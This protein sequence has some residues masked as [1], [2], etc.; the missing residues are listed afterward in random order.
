MH[1]RL[2]ARVV[3]DKL[4]ALFSDSGLRANELNATYDLGALLPA[5]A[6]ACENLDRTLPRVIASCNGSI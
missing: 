2:S 5:I 6:A 3:G 1:H 4:L